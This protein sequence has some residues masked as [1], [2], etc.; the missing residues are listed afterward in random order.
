MAALPQREGNR[1]TYSSFHHCEVEQYHAAT[2]SIKYVL[3]GTEHYFVK[4]KKFSVS[5]GNF[6]L[7]NNDQ[8]IDFYIR[9]RKRVNGFCIHLEEGL[10]QEMYT[11][12]LHGE[13]RLLDHPGER[14]GIPPFEEILY[15]DKENGLGGYLQ[16]M[17]RNFD[18]G[19]E[20]IAADPTAL[21]Y[22]LSQHLLLVQNSFPKASGRL[23]VVRNSTKQ[24]LVRRL[25]MAREMLDEEALGSMNIEAV[26]QG[27]ALSGSHL[28]RSFKKLYGVS[29]Y[30]YLLQRRIERAAELLSRREM[31][32]REVAMV[33][34]F[35]DGA[36][37]SKAF[38]K[39]RGVAPKA[40]S[41]QRTKEAEDFAQG[42]ANV[43]M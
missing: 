3:Q 35:A 17:A 30:Q 10:L 33:C 27:C 37:F 2:Y 21:Y 39:V 34:G 9:S 23:E 7:V 1:V 42:S 36:S 5:E 38:K 12:L 41:S 8:P 32:A 6:L 13:E 19:T 31:S 29:P 16:E 14:V 28:F 26:A 40:F 24:E 22:H 20:T 43:K 15:S 18:K 4:G 11:Q 25:E